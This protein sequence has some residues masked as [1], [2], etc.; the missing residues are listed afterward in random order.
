MP[1]LSSLSLPFKYLP[2]L[3]YLNDQSANWTLGEWSFSGGSLIFAK[4]SYD[5]PSPGGFKGF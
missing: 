3:S 2:Y 1:P 4:L 5:G